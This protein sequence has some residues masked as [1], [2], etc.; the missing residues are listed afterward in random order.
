MVN[1]EA[2]DQFSCLVASQATSVGPLALAA[3]PGALAAVLSQ[4]CLST[5][6]RSTELSLPCSKHA[7]QASFCRAQNGA[8]AAL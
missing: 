1:G 7:L 4:A 3:G 2:H 6:R 5:G 8:T